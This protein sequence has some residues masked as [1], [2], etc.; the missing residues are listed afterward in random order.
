MFQAFR[1]KEFQ[2]LLQDDPSMELSKVIYK[3]ISK[4]SLH[5]VA[6]KTPFFPYLDVIEWMTRRID[7]ESRKIPNFED[8]HVASYQAPIPNQLYH[9]KEEKVKVTSEWLNNKTKYIDLL[10]IMKGW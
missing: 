1:K 10:S 2:V 9:F 6:T 7:H 4:S 3:N 8:K 5:R